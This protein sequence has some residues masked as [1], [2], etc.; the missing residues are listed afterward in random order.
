[1]ADIVD[2]GEF[3]DDC[4]SSRKSSILRE[5]S[6]ISPHG[7]IN[8]R[9]SPLWTAKISLKSGVKCIHRSG[10]FW[11]TEQRESPKTDQRYPTSVPDVSDI[12]LH[13]TRFSAPFKDIFL[14]TNSLAVFSTVLRTLSIDLIEFHVKSVP[15]SWRHPE[16]AE[17]VPSSPS[18]S[19]NLTENL[20][21]GATFAII[22]PGRSR[23]WAEWLSICS[24]SPFL[25]GFI[26]LFLAC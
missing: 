14:A 20:R 8:M 24:R 26:P 9:K 12:E 23:S 2:R 21:H 4:Q 6:G 17:A 5:H 22:S 16:K 25:R 11:L 13:K 19:I 1:M 18:L 15:S 7:F 3:S 10:M